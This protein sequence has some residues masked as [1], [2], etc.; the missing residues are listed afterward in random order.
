M[1]IPVQKLRLLRRVGV[2]VVVLFAGAAWLGGIAAAQSP[3]AKAPPSRS[4]VRP[5]VAPKARTPVNNPVADPPST[6][7]TGWTCTGNCGTDGVDGV[8]TL[9][10]LGT[11]KYEWISTSGGASGVGK[12]P[13]GALGSETNGSTLAT[14]VFS[15][16]A[17]TALNFYFNFVTSDGGTFADYAW[18]ELFNSSNNP[19]ALLFT[20]RTVP[21][22]S[23]VPGSGLP[24]PLAT[25]TPASVPIIGG[26]PAWAP[27]GTSTGACFQAGCGY[28]GWVNSNYVIPTAGSYYL[29]VGVVNWVDTEY[30]TGL[31]LDGVTVG[32]APIGSSVPTLTTW[33]I[34]LL[35]GGLL[36]AGLFGVMAAT[37]GVAA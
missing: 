31:A 24:A 11:S 12:L 29:K 16:N 10:P 2:P 7:P 25:L 5:F 33:G 21:S 15:A 37:R 4:G 32:G 30:D 34:L 3:A 35:A 27:L 22:G 8:V 23:I 13:T 6:I 19:V 17:G 1:K 28:T 36:L 9:S 14:S 18:A 20:A 26:A